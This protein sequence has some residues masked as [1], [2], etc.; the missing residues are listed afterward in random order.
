MQLEGAECNYPVH[1]KEPLAIIRALKKW[2]SDLL[3]SHIYI[4][5]D[6]R[7]L[8][9][10]DTQRNL[11]RRQLRWQEFLSHYDM[12]ITYIQGEDNTVADA[13]S[14]VPPNT[15]P[16]E[17]AE[18]SQPHE[19][20]MRAHLVNAIL[21]ITTDQQVLNTIKT[22]YEDDKFC[23]RLAT[24]G[25]ANIKKVNDLWYISDPLVIPRHGNIRENL[26]RLAHDTLGHFGAHKSYATL[27]TAY[28]WPN[29]RRDLEA[30]YIPSCANCQRNKSRTTKSPGPLHPLPIPDARGDSITIDFIRPLPLDDGYDCIVSMTDRL[31]SDIHI[32]P[33][34]MNITAE[35]FAILFFDNWYCENGLPLDI[36]SDRNK[37]FV[38]QFWAALTKLT[39]V[40]LKMSSAYHPQT[41]GASERSNKTINQSLR[42]HVRRNQKGWVR[43]LPHVR[44]CIMNTVNTSTNFSPFQLRMGRSPRIIPPFV[45]DATTSTTPTTTASDIINHV[46]LDVD[47]AKDNL[48]QAKIAMA[49]HANMTRASDDVY[50]PG[51]WVMLSTLHCR[52]KYKCRGE[53]CVAKFFPRFD[54][55][56]EITNHHPET[57]SYMLDM[58]NSPNTY[59]TYHAA[60]LK[61]HHANDT[62]L[63][64]SRELPRPGPIVSPDGLEEYHVQ[65]VL[66]S[67][68]RGR[69]HQYLVRWTGYGPE[70][71]HWIAS[72]DFQD[73]ETLDKWEAL[74]A[75]MQ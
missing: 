32:I 21:S 12:T 75:E 18:N 27:C 10:F 69:G 17:F 26:F 58:P 20:W 37:L 45:T 74:E 44:F 14:R 63:F 40:K 30:S 3:G 4:Y 6:H 29:M 61:R 57:S 62:D 60:E 16:D 67:R 22:G 47:K 1:E 15:F 35:D 11:S 23:K 48:I 31:N 34:K 41:D 39:G 36:V 42:Y 54:S 28:Y 59:P 71:D 51:E 46:N 5:T 43:A 33:T 73:C 72:H 8:Q 50:K 38:S 13:L 55:P 25:M 52:N 65:E 64:P 56:F 68:K 7:T 66:N 53:K 19:V 9:N 2:R 70:H 24:S 49:H